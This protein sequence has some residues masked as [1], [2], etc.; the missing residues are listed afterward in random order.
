MNIQLPRCPLFSLPNRQRE[1]SRGSSVFTD[2]RWNDYEAEGCCRT[3]KTRPALFIIAEG[4][5]NFSFFFFYSLLNIYTLLQWLKIE[6]NSI[7]SLF[8]VDIFLPWTENDLS[9]LRE[10][11]CWL[12]AN[13]AAANEIPLSSKGKMKIRLFYFDID[14]S[15]R[16]PSCR[17]KTR[18][19]R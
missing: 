19:E 1:L 2:A 12:N 3:V 8:Q 10:H 14:L 15:E 4:F 18:T 5:L 16:R 6:S 13:R 17:R 9:S 7:I 11:K